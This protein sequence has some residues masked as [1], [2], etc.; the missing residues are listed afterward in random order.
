MYIYVLEVYDIGYLC[1]FFTFKSRILC[2]NENSL[3]NV[4]KLRDLYV[5]FL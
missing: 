2:E 1:L 5:L 3:I 4:K